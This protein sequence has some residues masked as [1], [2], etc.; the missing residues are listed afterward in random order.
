MGTIDKRT[1][2]NE[3]RILAVESHM[4]MTNEADEDVESEPKTFTGKHK[5]IDFDTNDFKFDM[6]RLNFYNSIPCETE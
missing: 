2:L 6:N 3:L 1:E 5:A 4:K